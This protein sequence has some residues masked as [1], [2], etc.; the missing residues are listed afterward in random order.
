MLSKL[1]RSAASSFPPRTAHV[2]TSA[3]PPRQNPTFSRSI[4]TSRYPR[5]SSPHSAP[6]PSLQIVTN[7]QPIPLIRNNFV[8][9]K[10]EVGLGWVTVETILQNRLRPQPVSLQVLNL[11]KNDYQRLSVETAQKTLRFL[12]VR[13]TVK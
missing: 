13:A 10:L 9:R 2:C 1:I 5:T 7:P 6:G 11:A 4:A 3:R 12:Q 8:F